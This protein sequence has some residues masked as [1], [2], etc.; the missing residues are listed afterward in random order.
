MR[1]KIVGH[2]NAHG[3]YPAP[4]VPICRDSVTKRLVAVYVDEP[5][6][7]S[8]EE[9]AE[10]AFFTRHTG[11]TELEQIFS[12]F[13]PST[14]S[15]LALCD[16]EFRLFKIA[17]EVAFYKEM[18]SDKTFSSSNIFFRLSYARATNDSGLIA[19]EKAVC[20]QWLD[21]EGC[22]YGISL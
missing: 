17:D 1:Y 13:N 5:D 3:K 6:K 21:K 15:I 7:I 20:Q 12:G 10:N 18:L 22:G 16:R 4:I 8:T 11:D 2:V 14:D 9:V 19:E